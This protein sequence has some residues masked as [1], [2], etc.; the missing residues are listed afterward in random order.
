[1]RARRALAGLPGGGASPLAS[2]LDA[3][4]TL[5]RQEKRAG[6]TPFVIVLTD[7]RANMARDGR[8]GREAAEGDALAVAKLL[9][10]GAHSVLIVDTAPRPQP[11]AR[12]LA[13]EAGGRSLVLPQARA[14]SL[15]AAVRGEM[16]PR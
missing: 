13:A 4:L 10:A 1:V 11:F 9:R 3:A 6:R 7:G 5:A 12:T 16:G 2:G 8:T 15:A 14:D